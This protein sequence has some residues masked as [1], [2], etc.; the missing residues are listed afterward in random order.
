VAQRQLGHKTDMSRYYLDQTQLAD[1]QAAD[2]LP[3]L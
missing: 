3:S 1:V 2:V